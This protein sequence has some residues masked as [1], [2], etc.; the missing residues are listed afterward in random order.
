MNEAIDA[1]PGTNHTAARF[2]FQVLGHAGLFAHLDDTTLLVDP[3]LLGSCYWRSWWHYPP[4]APPSDA[5]LSPDFLYLTHHHFDHFH[6]PS[7]R[8]IDKRAHVLI[9]KFGVDVMRR[10]CESLGFQTVTELAHG[11][12]F[13]PVPGL[14]IASFQYGFDDTALLI[15]D[16]KTVIGDFNDCKIRGR[17]L[18][19]IRD[20]FGPITF[21]LKN[22]SWAMSY[23]NRYDA[24]DA[25]DLALLS[26][27]DYAADFL[28]TVRE[29]RPRYAVPFAS[30]VCFLHPETFDLNDEVI[31]P[32]DVQKAFHAANIAGT[33]FVEMAPGDSWESDTGF[34]CTD[35]DFYVDRAERLVRMQ[36]EVEPKI[37]EETA[38]ERDRAL[39][40][41]QF[42]S[43]LGRFLR[44][45]PPG[46][47][48]LVRRPV[49]F[50]VPSDSHPWWTLDFRTRR[51]RRERE[52]GADVGSRVR[53]PEGVLADS[54]GKGVLGIVP[55]SMRMRVRVASGAIGNDF[56]FWGLLSLWEIGYLPAHRVANRRMVE[57]AWRRRREGLEFGA[58]LMRRGPLVARLKSNLMSD[59]ERFP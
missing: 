53:I 5:L 54:I 58:S 49:S 31:T 59:S 52:P 1:T 56:L 12:V 26:R 50:E 36:Q 2:G 39:T 21:L 55:I 22:H 47:R 8:R 9:P 28:D 43:Y 48:W 20:T 16:G 6:Y 57:A 14:S 10:E 30:M 13:E 17:P 3:W 7:M 27:D 29:L 33:E 11:E 19:Q 24:E 45:L 51:V 46:I 44:A 42:E 34:H 38:R 15:T 23:P 41:E 32:R 18:R 25:G 4:V 40:F 35:T 37:D